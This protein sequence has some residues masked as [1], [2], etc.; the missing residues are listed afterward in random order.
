MHFNVT[1]SNFSLI[2]AA[3]K[4]GSKH[5]SKA[6]SALKRIKELADGKTLGEVISNG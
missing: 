5:A 4:S 3:E 1:F 2:Q 6:K